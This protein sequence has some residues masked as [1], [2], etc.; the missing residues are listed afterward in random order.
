VAFTLTLGPITLTGLELSMIVT[1]LVML[2]YTSAGGL[3]AVVITDSLQFF[4]I[5]IVSFLVCP[6]AFIA[7]GDSWNMTV[8]IQ[9]LI[10]EAPAGY[11]GFSEVW[12]KPWF[13][14]AYLLSTFVGY[15]AAWHI[16]QRYYSVPTERDSRK[17]ALLCAGLSLVLPF[18]WIAPTLAARVLFP[19]IASMWPGDPHPEESAFVTLALT[20]LPNGLI[21]LTLSAIL[22]AAMTSIDTQLNYLASIL[23]RDVYVRVRTTPAGVL[24]GEKEQLT[25]SRITAIILG[26]LATATAIFF[27]RWK[28]VFEVALNYYSWFGPSMLTPVMLG[29]LIRRTPSWS[30]IASSTA[31]LIVV[32]FVNVFISFDG[33]QYEA[34]IIAGIGISSIVFLLTALWPERSVAV[35]ERIKAFFVDQD[36]PANDE[37]LRW[38]GNA[39]SS[40][41]I[42]GVL[43]AGIG[44]VVVLLGLVPASLPVHILTVV[45]GAGTA[46]LGWLMTWY[47]RRQSRIINRG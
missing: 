30:A 8:G 22:A 31:G 35:L 37:D 9:R 21:G 41:Q 43:T 5:L 38:S 46:F 33:F 32:L 15:N 42:V 16:G 44:S 3:W 34:N 27:Q 45:L 24:P 20:L 47:F 10:A 14:F 23:I 4:I 13:Y 40:Y 28:S 1:G 26:L 17:M 18:L 2:I 7:L 29:F 11:L 12:T 36:T 6:L 25:A 39:L 19:D